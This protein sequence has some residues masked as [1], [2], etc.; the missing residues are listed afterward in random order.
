MKTNFSRRKFIKLS[1]LSSAFLGFTGFGPGIRKENISETIESISS[2]PMRKGNSVIGL[3]VPPIKQVKV[4]FIGLGNRGSQHLPI[5][6]ALCPDKAVITAMCDVQKNKVDAALEE[7][8]KSG[9][10]QKPAVYSGS[11][12]IWK[13]MIKRD[14]IDLVIIATPWEDHAS[15][16]LLSMQRQTCCR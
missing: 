6:D 4:A 7:L 14:D 16:C 2:S 13:E 8:A 5:V 9:H 15:M 12:D 1:A 11:L 3:K 10:G